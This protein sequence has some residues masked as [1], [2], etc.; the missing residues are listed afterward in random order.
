MV[1]DAAVRLL[2]RREHSQFELARK[3]AGRGHPGD[4][5]VEIIGDLASAGLQSD[6]RFAQAFVRSASGRGQG[7]LK[8]R[9]GLSGRGV[10]DD[11]ASAHLDLDADD[12]TERA[13]KASRKRFGPAPPQNRADWARRARFLAGRGFPSGM[14]AKVL[15]SLGGGS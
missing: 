1:R 12:W 7:P 8:I 5:I 11:I 9:A 4:L 3:L 2:A 15:G 10:D 6:D 14:V 13:A